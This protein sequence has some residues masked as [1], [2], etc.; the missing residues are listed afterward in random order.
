MNDQQRYEDAVRIQRE[1]D[2]LATVTNQNMIADMAAAHVTSGAA[3]A[4][5]CADMILMGMVLS[6]DG[7]MAAAM[8]ELR[9]RPSDAGYQEYDRPDGYQGRHRA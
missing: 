1:I 4:G 3:V 2:R 7:A 5:F 6:A 9:V 8:N